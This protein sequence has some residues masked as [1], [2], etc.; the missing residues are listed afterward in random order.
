VATRIDGDNVTVPG[1]VSVSGPPTSLAHVPVMGNTGFL[2]GYVKSL[3]LNAAAP[4]DLAVL[5]I[6]SANYIPIRCCVYNPSGN[7]AAATLGLYTAAGG[8]GIAIVAPTLLANLTAQGKFQELTIAALTD[9][10]V[11]GLLYP[12]LT[13]AAGAPGIASLVMEYRDLSLI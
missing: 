8:G 10:V 1:Q 13:V 11:A 12:R 9:A 2:R 5:S 4:I 7:V 6:L 3:N